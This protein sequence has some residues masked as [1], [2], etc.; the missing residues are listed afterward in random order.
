MI[1]ELILMAALVALAWAATLI[2]PFAFN[3]HESYFL[4]LVERVGNKAL[5]DMPE[6]QTEAYKA[7]DHRLSQMRIRATTEDKMRR[8]VIHYMTFSE[9][10]NRR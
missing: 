10:V 8:F 7:L 3:Y 5:R 2:P 1:G 9:I 6:G 4:D